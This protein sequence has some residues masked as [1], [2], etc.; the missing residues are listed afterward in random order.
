MYN[1]LGIPEF[2]KHAHPALCI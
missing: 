1:I 2:V